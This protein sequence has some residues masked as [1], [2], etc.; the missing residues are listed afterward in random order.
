MTRA[1]HFTYFITSVVSVFKVERLKPREGKWVPLIT[2]LLGGRVRTEPRYLDHK[3]KAFSLQHPS[4][5][6]LWAHWCWGQGHTFP[7]PS[8]GLHAGWSGFP[9]PP[10]F[11]PSALRVLLLLSLYHILSLA[12][13]RLMVD[14]PDT[15]PRDS[16]PADT[17]AA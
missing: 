3:S 8:P 5:P 17:E 2:Q 12:H 11:F 7:G 15:E 9:A 4:H 14:D 16:F 10:F 13:T 1:P 6:G